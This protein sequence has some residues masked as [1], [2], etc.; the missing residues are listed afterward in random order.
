MHIL[1]GEYKGKKLLVD[2]RITKPTT[3]KT[4]QAIFSILGEKIIG[5]NVLDLFCGS[6][7]VGI[8]MISLGAKSLISIDKNISMAIKNFREI[9]ANIIF[10]KNDSLRSI[11]K[12]SQNNHKF[13]IIFLDPPYKYDNKDDLLIA[14]SK[15]DILDKEGVV[16]FET[17]KYTTFA[18][19][20]GSLYRR[21]EYNYGLAKI[22]LFEMK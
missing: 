16:L 3:S 10:Y 22:T 12:L 1:A 15:F 8:E 17:D 19:N 7:S 9:N 18:E 20:I 11:K 14:I 21:K 6:G 5:A 2:E 4:K 13:D